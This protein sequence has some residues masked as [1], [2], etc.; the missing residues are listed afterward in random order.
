M[1]T[2]TTFA[3]MGNIHF[4]LSGTFAIKY[5]PVE[6]EYPRE[7]CLIDRWGPVEDID[8]EQ[9]TYLPEAGL[10]WVEAGQG[11]FYGLEGEGMIYPNHLYEYYNLIVLRPNWVPAK[12]ALNIVEGKMGL[13]SNGKH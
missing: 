3:Y 1:I 5:L 4:K 12:I 2:T 9:T 8:K 11:V 10:E 6:V 13:N 7:F